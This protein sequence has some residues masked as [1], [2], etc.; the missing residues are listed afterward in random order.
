MCLRGVSAHCG[1]G[2]S[3]GNTLLNSSTV[4]AGWVVV[5]VLKRCQQGVLESAND[6]FMHEEGQ[7]RYITRWP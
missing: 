4:L 5:L 6:V 1:E 7:R 2:K 3:Q